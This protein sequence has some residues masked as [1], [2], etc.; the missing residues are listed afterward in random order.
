MAYWIGLYKYGVRAVHHW[1]GKEEGT[2]VYLECLPHHHRHHGES[3]NPRLKTLWGGEKRL[4]E[5]ENVGQNSLLQT[6]L[7]YPGCWA[8]AG[9]RRRR[10]FSEDSSGPLWCRRRPG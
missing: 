6:F 2:L 3:K 10:I 7:I 1:M 9:F 5:I 8:A 4:Y